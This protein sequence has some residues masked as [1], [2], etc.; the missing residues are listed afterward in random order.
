MTTRAKA[1]LALLAA[2]FLFS[3]GGAVIKATSLGGWQVA[4]L[5]SGVAAVALAALFP[6]ARRGIS[7]RAA[8]VGLAYA[9]TVLQFVLATKLTTAANAIFLQS[10]APLYLLAIG[11]LVLKERVRP[12]DLGVLLLVA[13][14]LVAVLSDGQRAQASAPDPVTGNVLGTV[15]GLT[16]AL[17]ITGLRSLR[18]RGHEAAEPPDEDPAVAGPRPRAVTRPQ[19][20]RDGALAAVTLGN[21]F[22]CLAA[23]PFALASGGTDGLSATDALLVV[24]LG[25]GQIGLAY[26]ALTWG[27]RHVPALSASLLLLVEP[28]LNPLWAFAAQGEVPGALACLGGALILGATVLDTWLRGRE[29]VPPAPA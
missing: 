8:L 2:A 17:T 16:W 5:R 20:R 29:A 22:A 23:M 1:R 10:S 24:W 9:A 26:V 15:A 21:L 7:G 11:P 19:V 14:G 28:A 18:D 6:A 27:L 13:A 3:T 12:R 25:L 4:W